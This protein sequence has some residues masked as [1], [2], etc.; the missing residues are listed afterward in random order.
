MARVRFPDVNQGRYY[1]PRF[2]RTH[3][4]TSVLSYHANKQWTFSTVFQYATGQPYTLPLGQTPEYDTP[5]RSY[6]RKILTIGRVNASRLPAYSRLDLSAT[7]KG[8]FL[9]LMPAE[10]SL[11]IINVYARR[12]VWYYKFNLNGSSYSIERVK[13]LPIV[14]SVSYTIHF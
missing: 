11:Q 7:R 8:T 14:P 5:F 10:L 1:P 13:S 3:D 12:N 4:L 9:G 6:W 2:D